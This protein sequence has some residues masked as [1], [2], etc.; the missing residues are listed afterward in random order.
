MAD[1]IHLNIIRSTS[2]STSRSTSTSTT[3]LSSSTAS[4]ADSSL[5]EHYDYIPK[6]FD[7]MI[8]C[9]LYTIDCCS[10][11]ISKCCWIPGLFK[12]L[13]NK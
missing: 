2:T 13:C 1:P 10:V 9:C 4:S 12:G 5:R 6:C 11:K 7:K 8:F 3:D